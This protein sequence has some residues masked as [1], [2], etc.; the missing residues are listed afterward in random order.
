MPSENREVCILPSNADGR[1]IVAARDM[2]STAPRTVCAL[3]ALVQLASCVASH[4]R[5]IDSGDAG[6]AA[7][8]LPAI[9]YEIALVRTP[10]LCVRVSL[11]TRGAADGVTTFAL[12]EGWGGVT[13]AGSSVHD[14]AVRDAHGA[15]L[16][17]EH[18]A[19]HRWTVRHEGGEPLSVSYA[20]LPNER[21]SSSEPS[22]H[23]GP[24]LN[25]KLFHAIGNVSLLRPEHVDGEAPRDIALAW[26]GFDEA[27]WKIA[28]SFGIGP[29]AIRTRASL[30]DFRQA[31][32]VAG[33]L[34]LHTKTI[35]GK[36]LSIAIAGDDWGFDDGEFVVLAAGIVEAERAF[37]EDWEV[38]HYLISLI[39]VGKREPGRI[40]L[41]GTGLAHSFATFM[42]PGLELKAG[43]R[44]A[45]MIQHLLAHEM[46]HEW[47]GRVLQ[48][49]QPE[50]L[51]YWFSEGFTDFFARRLM[52]RAGRLTVDQYAQDV[53]ASLAEY[54]LSPARNYPNQR[55]RSDFWK[56]RA[57]TN[58]PYRRGDVV[59][60]V[61][62]EAMRERSHGE[63]CLD[64][65]MRELVQR[66]RRGERVDCDSLFRA[67]EIETYP[68]VAARVRGIVVDGETAELDPFTFQPCL[69]LRMAPMGP[70]DLGFDLERSRAEKEVRGVRTGSRAE[71][72]GLRDG[73]KL[74]AISVHGD[75]IDIPV[76][77]DVQR[78][79]ERRR[80]TWLPQGEP[81]A[82]PQ[83]SVRESARSADCTRL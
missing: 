9:A 19:G 20:L 54:M 83:F 51:V 29:A 74:L 68:D 16:A 37:F 32:F 17:V 77:A 14:L 65:L 26:R 18:P 82:V 56:D 64:D 12:D 61:V 38:P 57:V 1:R 35:H 59:A 10:S 21:Q 15:S 23:Y 6:G 11:E 27:G 7:D 79:G 42:T 40:S 8:A 78:D 43:S 45:L 4:A 80:I 39:P 50:E 69:Q 31:V 63:R 44:D 36:P 3:A 30:N 28:S 66:G 33:D 60:I 47:N 48:R 41:G 81:T 62:D 71:A 24:I 2:K 58:L 5:S 67:I 52:F 13:D 70:Y 34:R 46:F 73:E 72:A 53:D 76:E 25:A 75:R 55:I 49:V 22:V